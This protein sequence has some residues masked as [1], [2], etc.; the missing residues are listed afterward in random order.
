M[1]CAATDGAM[2]DRWRQW[3]AAIGYGGGGRGSDWVWGGG[4]PNTSWR[5]GKAELF[6][7]R[8][9]Y[10]KQQRTQCLAHSQTPFLFLP[11]SRKR[12]T[13][14]CSLAA[15]SA[16]DGAAREEEEEEEGYYVVE[17][18]EEEEE[19][20]EDGGEQEELV[21][22]K[23]KE[24][25]DDVEEK[26]RLFVGNL[27]YSMTSSELGELFREAGQVD[28]VE[29]I[30]D[31]VTDR[32][33]GFAFL[34]MGSFEEAKRVIRMFDGS[35]VAGRTLKVNFP[36]VPRGGERE[37]MGPMIRNNYRGYVDSPYK[38]YA[39]NLSWILTSEGLKEAFENQP[40]FLGAKVIYERASGRSRGFGFVSFG[41]L[42]EAE[43][44]VNALNGETHATDMLKRKYDV[45][46]LDEDVPA[47]PN[48]KLLPTARALYIEG[49][50]NRKL[51][52]MGVVMVSTAA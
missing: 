48:V 27:P 1:H 39:G 13:A 42:E 23:E 34:M 2:C 6:K 16:F 40:G 21:E 50:L 18:E 3:T 32:S 26:R 11:F 37:V 10:P 25:D 46:H 43:A 49:A 17:E 29:I 33:R 52:S 8:E 38:V 36:E 28:S 7:L 19:F 15:A 44:A 47:I 14:F 4:G 35:Q 45:M 30:Y 9:G 24:G 20:E 22:A 5:T 12:S 31:R 41:S 51:N